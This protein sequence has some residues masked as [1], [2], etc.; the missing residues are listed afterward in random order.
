[1][2]NENVG[3]ITKD[4][5]LIQTEERPQ[6]SATEIGGERGYL[7]FPRA[8]LHRE[9]TFVPYHNYLATILLGLGLAEKIVHFIINEQ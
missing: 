6:G 1:M 8:I 3:G 7:C 4:A 2:D 9:T 5:M